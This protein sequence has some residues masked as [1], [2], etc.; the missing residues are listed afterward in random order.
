MRGMRPGAAG[1]RFGVALLVA[2]V[3]ILAS[4]PVAASQPLPGVEGAA[5]VRIILALLLVLAMIAG[6]AWML[7]RYGP[8]QGAVSGEMRVLA[9]L[10][11]G[12]RERVVL[13]QIGETQLLLG[14]APGRVQTLHVLDRPVTGAGGGLAASQEAQGGP[15]AERLRRMMQQPGK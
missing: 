11:V 4:G 15:F 3:N 8:V 9:S 6:L 2:S 14:V 12:H 13:V 1:R 7:R 10:S 5:V